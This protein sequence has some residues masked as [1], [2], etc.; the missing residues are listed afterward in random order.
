MGAVSHQGRLGSMAPTN[1]SARTGGW[2]QSERSLQGLEPSERG[3]PKREPIGKPRY[4]DLE[5]S[6]T[7]DPPC[8]GHRG[9]QSPDPAWHRVAAR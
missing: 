7:E 9:D 2:A 3:A 4:L 8:H 5:R 6:E 1:D